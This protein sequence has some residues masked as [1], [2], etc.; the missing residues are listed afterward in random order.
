MFSYP[1]SQNDGKREGLEPVQPFLTIPNSFW[2]IASL[3]HATIEDAPQQAN[4]TDGVVDS[5]GDSRGHSLIR[6][7]H[8]F[9]TFS[10]VHH[11]NQIAEVVSS[12]RD[13]WT[14]RLAALSSVLSRIALGASE[15]V[16]EHGTVSNTIHDLTHRV[17]RTN[18]LN[19]MTALVVFGE[20]AGHKTWFVI[21]ATPDH[22]QHVIQKI[23]KRVTAIYAV[24]AYSDG[25]VPCLALTNF[26]CG[27]KGITFVCIPSPG[28]VFILSL[29]PLPVRCLATPPDLPYIDRPKLF[30][31]SIIVIQEEFLETEE[32]EHS[33][34]AYDH[35]PEKATVKAEVQTRTLDWINTLPVEAQTGRAFFV[36]GDEGSGDR[37]EP[38][39]K[40]K[41]EN[42]ATMDLS[43]P[44]LHPK[45]PQTLRKQSGCC[46]QK[47]NKTPD[48]DSCS[49]WQLLGAKSTMD[50][51]L[52]ELTQSKL[53]TVKDSNGE[54][55][56]FARP[57]LPTDVH[58]HLVTLAAGFDEDFIRLNDVSPAGQ[59]EA[60]RAFISCSTGF[61]LAADELERLL[62]ELSTLLAP[63]SGILETP[64]RNFCLT[65]SH[66][67]QEP[68]SSHCR[69]LN[70][71]NGNGNDMEMAD[72]GPN[73]SDNPSRRRSEEG[74]GGSEATVA[75]SDKS[76]GGDGGD[77]IS[78]SP[79][80]VGV[81]EPY[82]AFDI[83]FKVKPSP[84][85]RDMHYLRLKGTL[86]SKE[87]GTQY[88]T[89]PDTISTS[90]VRFRKLE[91]HRTCNISDGRKESY[92]QFY[93]RVD[94]ETSHKGPIYLNNVY[95]KSSQRIVDG[96]TKLDITSWLPF[97]ATV[98]P[99][100]SVSKTQTR[101]T[102]MAKEHTENGA[103]I[104]QVDTS[105]GLRWAYHVDDEWTR[106]NGLRLTDTPESGRR[107]PEKLHVTVHFRNIG[108]QV[109][110]ALPLNLTKTW[111]VH[112]DVNV[113]VG[114]DCK[115]KLGGQ[116]KDTY[117]YGNHGV[118]ENG[119][120][121]YALNDRD[122][123]APDILA[124]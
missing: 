1:D 56:M 10:P 114:R 16:S 82:A 24:L 109:T 41:I 66:N 75:G 65:P 15:R 70:R 78:P 20:K 63:F 17:A 72:N 79:S 7:R 117:L 29:G 97:L 4:P 81:A 26:Q 116:V 27:P 57:I 120:L 42:A 58:Q 85:C 71:G 47:C 104:E 80:G 13:H 118:P 25:S 18:G 99:S 124:S 14:N 22:T 96:K 11:E 33:I 119:T 32:Q 51:P 54:C 62:V 61:K 106:Q 2:F 8:V 100:V 74:D 40:G 31:S 90:R 43:R 98:S 50:Q 38:M 53:E 12:T 28:F 112:R 23:Y 69:H 77:P 83:K 19:K 121:F 95:P 111:H 123:M 105:R 39:R 68:T 9:A 73:E 115:H 107:C 76:S 55:S 36:S 88:Y 113:W 103:R 89:S 6:T 35:C 91:F 3:S 45:F 92:H 122:C 49:I 64:T 52:K 46:I 86:E 37:N 94:V 108:V 59:F 21:H 60:Q 102:A 30:L 110:M 48:D 5:D 87:L 101:K 93:A 67:D 34:D 44:L 84:S